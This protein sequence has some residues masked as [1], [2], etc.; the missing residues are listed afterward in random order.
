[1]ISRIVIALGLAL[2]LSACAGKSDLAEP[3]ANLGNFVLGH[4][5]VVVD[6]VQKVPISRDADPKDWEV[7]MKKAIEDRFGQKRYQGDRIFNL[8]ISV[9]AYAL[10]PP[11]IPVIASP[12][13][14]VVITASIWD[15]A[16]Q[17]KL[18]AEGVQFTV[19]EGLNGETVVGTGL[20]RTADEQMEALTY[21]AAKR[22]ERWLLEN[23]QWFGLS[24]APTA[25]P[26]STNAANLAA[27]ASLPAPAAQQA[28]QSLGQSATLAQQQIPQAA[29]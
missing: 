10:A 2:G 17:Q 20:T 15:D 14:A 6:N 1:M 27:N 29:R 16:S 13:S 18:N 3:P 24:A 23:P 25:V 26:S 7:S 21:N 22:V 9:D 4:N 28:A 5:I 11:G 19:F 12:K 8:G